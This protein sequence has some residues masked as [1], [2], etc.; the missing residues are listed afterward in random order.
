MLGLHFPG[1]L[2]ECSVEVDCNW[3]IASIVVH[4]EESGLA[5]YFPESISGMVTFI[6]GIFWRRLAWALTAASWGRG[7]RCLC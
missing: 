7:T 4:S 6:P 3:E 2:S 1:E 5:E